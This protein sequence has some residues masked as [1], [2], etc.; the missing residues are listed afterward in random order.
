ME[1]NQ[2][3]L[4]ELVATKLASDGRFLDR[5]EERL[6]AEVT[7]RIK[8]AV[9]GAAERIISDA[10]TS[11][12]QNWRDI[13]IHRTNNWGEP[14]GPAVSLPQ[15]CEEQIISRADN[16]YGGKSSISEAAQKIVRE[17]VTDAVNAILKENKAVLDNMVTATLTAELAKRVR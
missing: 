12:F 8:S 3:T 5:V 1:I 14:N 2:D 7:S 4:S 10:V 9:E 16:R 15:W 6:D 13:K 11:A 17:R